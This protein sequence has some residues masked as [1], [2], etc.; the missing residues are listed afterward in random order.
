MEKIEKLG[1]YIHIPFCKQKCLYCDFF[2][3]SKFDDS[4]FEKYFDSLII[5]LTIRLNHYYQTHSKITH[6]INTIYIGGGTPSVVPTY[7][8][9][10]FLAKLFSIIDKT[11][12]EEMTIEMNPESV[13][14]SLIAYIS[15]YSF[16]RLSIGIQTTNDDSL[17]EVG[18]IAKCI[19]IDS[20]LNI[21][22]CSSVK[23]TSVDFIHSLPYNRAG[24]SKKDIAYVLDRLE[25]KHISLYF[26][27]IDDEHTLKNKWDAVSMSEDDSVADYLDTLEYMYSQG[28]KRYEISNFSTAEKY[29]SKHNN[30]YWNINDYIGIGLSACGCYGNIRYTNTSDLQKYFCGLENNR[31]EQSIEALDSCIREKEFIF[32]SLR[33]AS[34]LDVN[35]YQ[36]LFKQDFFERYK[37]IIKKYESYFVINDGF[38]FLTDISMLYANTIISSFFE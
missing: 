27:E 32:L 12:I 19:D 4:I 25:I 28:F 6:I 14:E 3:C 10:R 1:L 7:I 18:R 21:I 37:S 15:G 36:K 9:E 11:N 38:I 13:D 29:Q 23:N 35:R 26:L 30:H 33:K 22:K 24:Q 8:Y 31:L 20:A 2:S 34:G 17:F 5:E 16:A